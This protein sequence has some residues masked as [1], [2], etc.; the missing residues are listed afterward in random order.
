V[1]VDASTGAISEESHATT[2]SPFNTINST[3]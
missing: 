1:G 3:I 2:K